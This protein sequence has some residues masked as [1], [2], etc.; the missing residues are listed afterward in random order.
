MLSGGFSM[1]RII[2]IQN[3]KEAV[4][5]LLQFKNKNY[6]LIDVRLENV[7]LKRINLLVENDLFSKNDI[8]VNSLTL[9]EI[10]NQDI[11]GGSHHYHGLTPEEIVDTLA[12]ITDPYCVIKTKFSRYAIMST[13][14][15]HFGE[16]LMV[17][18]EV[19][20]GLSNDPKA[21]INKLIT[22]YPKDDIDKAIEN[23]DAKDVLY[24]K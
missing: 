20:S 2:N 8:Y 21:N 3:K 5:S 13:N 16:Q 18:I 1:N 19:G 14:V 11:G 4:Q 7:H 23:T 12:N 9:K 17:I 22:I 24:K 15:S 6:V 10:M